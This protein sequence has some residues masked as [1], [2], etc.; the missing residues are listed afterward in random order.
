[1]IYK[2]LS[3]DIWTS[4]RQ[5]CNAAVAHFLNNNGVQQSRLLALWQQQGAHNGENIVAR[6]SNVVVDWKVD[7]NRNTLVSDNASN[8]I[9]VFKT[10]SKV[11]R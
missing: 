4:I 2:L 7:I 3:V 11:W 9:T 8:N 5:A 10:F 6:V 1:M